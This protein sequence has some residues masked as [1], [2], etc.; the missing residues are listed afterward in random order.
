MTSSSAQFLSSSPTSSITAAVT[1]THILGLLSLIKSIYCIKELGFDYSV[2]QII[3][4]VSSG[5]LFVR[6]AGQF[7]SWKLALTRTTRK[8][9]F[10]TLL[11]PHIA[12]RLH[13][14]GTHIA[15]N[16][17]FISFQVVRRGLRPSDLAQHRQDGFI[18]PTQVHIKLWQD[19][20]SQ[21]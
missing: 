14:F 12:T 7:T 19:K 5:P 15:K 16:F 13:Q 2:L 9:T 18:K 3:P 11:N 21:K 8:N 6:S 10:V 20:Q 4:L 1:L 17:L